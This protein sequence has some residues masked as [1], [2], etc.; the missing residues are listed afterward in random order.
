MNW[1]DQVVHRIAKAPDNGRSAPTAARAPLASAWENLPDPALMIDPHGRVLSCNRAFGDALGMPPEAIAGRRL[2][3][4]LGRE[5]GR[6]VALSWLLEALE[7]QPELRGFEID[8]PGPAGAVRTYEGAA[9]K[10]ET[11]DGVQLVLTWRD[12]TERSRQERVLRSRLANLEE[13]VT[14]QTAELADKVKALARANSELQELDQQ[15]AELISL[16]SHQIRAPL[17]NMLGAVERMS[18]ACPSPTSVCGR[19]F[20]ILRDQTLRLNRLVRDVLSMTRIETGDLAV[21]IEPVSVMP[22]LQQTVDQISARG[23]R[24]FNLPYAPVLPLVM[25]DRDCLA[26]VLANLLDNADKYSPPEAAVEVE[27]R[28]TEREV[29]LSVLDA[30]PGLSEG[31]LDRVFDKFYRAERGDSQRSYGYGLGLYVCRR[32]IEA[33]DGRIWAE[34][35]SEGGARFSLALGVDQAV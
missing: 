8:L 18:D 14:E 3:G 32:L 23:E 2:A 34:N 21:Q 5:E 11:E 25:A 12:V 19:M 31:D 20:G 4:V 7:R 27:V 1:F 9:R 17:T 28:A 29:V 13:Q 33:Q 16:V 10:V 35:R 6:S 22:I 30:G 15:R 26:E 24:S